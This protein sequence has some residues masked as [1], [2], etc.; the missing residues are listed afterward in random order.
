MEK[1]H[2]ARIKRRFMA[3]I[4]EKSAITCD[5]SEKGMQIAMSTNPKTVIVDISIDL[6]KTKYSFKGKVKWIRRNPVKKT[7]NIGIYLENIPI[8]YNKKLQELFPVLAVDNETQVEIDD[9]NS[10]FGI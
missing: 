1:R 10:M 8:D 2:G 9:I 7:S 6:D 4:S 3:K 5:I